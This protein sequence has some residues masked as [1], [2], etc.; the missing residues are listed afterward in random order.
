ME[1]EMGPC[2]KFSLYHLMELEPGEETLA[3][4]NKS[5]GATKGAQLLHSSVAIRGMGRPLLPDDDFRSAIALRQDSFA[6]PPPDEATRVRKEDKPKAGI[7][8]PEKLSDIAEILRS[9]NAGPYEIT[10]DVVFD[11]E[12]SFNFIKK[13]DLLSRE[14]VARALQVSQEDI[15]WIGFYDPAIAFKVTIPRYRGGKKASAGSFM[16]NDIHGSQQHLGLFKLK[17]PE[18]AFPGALISR[19]RSAL[20]QPWYGYLALTTTLWAVSKSAPARRL[21]SR[22]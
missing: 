8:P 12:A 19:I 9:K 5:N 22:N 4:G 6:Q 21:F 2:A 7:Q 20:D 17:L 10:M 18:P 14:N 1:L 13:S 15:I 11:S 16:E 3:P